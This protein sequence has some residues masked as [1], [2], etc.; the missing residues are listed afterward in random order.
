[1]GEKRGGCFLRGFFFSSST[2]LSLPY[3]SLD[4][5]PVGN[6]ASHPLSPNTM[7][8]AEPNAIDKREQFSRKPHGD[9]LVTHRSGNQEIFPQV[10]LNCLVGGWSFLHCFRAFLSANREGH[11]RPFLSNIDL[12]LGLAVSPHVV[13]LA[14]P[15]PGGLNRAEHTRH[16]AS[17]WAT[18]VCRAS[19]W[20]SWRLSFGM[21]KATRSTKQTS[22][23]A[24]A[25][26]IANP[27]ILSLPRRTAGLGGLLSPC[28]RPGSPGEAHRDETH[29]H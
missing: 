1:M 8:L 11:Q 21:S 13:H 12:L 6:R 15:L 27:F 24:S 14:H 3:A 17:N 4:N 19:I 20:L 2:R 28:P 9:G 23:P 10:H 25:R 26:P 22:T 7:S 16:L 5:L 18:C 29:S